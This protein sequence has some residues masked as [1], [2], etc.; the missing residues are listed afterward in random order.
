MSW[1]HSQ[2]PCDRTIS[3][4]PQTPTPGNAAGSRLECPRGLC[5]ACCQATCRTAAGAPSTPCTPLLTDPPEGREQLQCEGPGLAQAHRLLPPASCPPHSLI[6][7]PSSSGLSPLQASA[8][9]AP[10]LGP[11]SGSSLLAPLS[12][13]PQDF[14]PS[15]PLAWLNPGLRMERRGKRRKVSPHDRYPS[16]RHKNEPSVRKK[17][18]VKLKK[19]KKTKDL[20]E[21]KK[22]VVMV[23]TQ[24]RSPLN[25]SSSPRPGQG[26]P[27]PL[28][29]SPLPTKA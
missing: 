17:G 14:S 19:G 5:D 12:A 11:P 20:Q 27:F 24:N 29:F 9:D 25:T 26:C 6:P 22:E 15:A 28:C 8:S 13:Q 1:F 2:T 10:H 16:Q 7:D 4:H 23:R 21:L 3:K 18:K